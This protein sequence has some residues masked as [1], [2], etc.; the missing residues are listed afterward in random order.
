MPKNGTGLLPF[1]SALRLLV[2]IALDVIKPPLNAAHA[3]LLRHSFLRLDSSPY[4][5]LADPVVSA[6]CILSPLQTVIASGH[7][8]Q[9]LRV[10]VRTMVVLRA[11]VG[12]QFGRRVLG[13]INVERHVLV[14]IE[15]LVPKP[16]VLLMLFFALQ[17]A[18][19]VPMRVNV[20]RR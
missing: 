20:H 5:L 10:A 11:V 9:L 18:V 17:Y 4:F 16:K 15:A 2:Y 1:E 13:F 6:K 12:G 19:D 14:H 8:F 7:R 3:Y